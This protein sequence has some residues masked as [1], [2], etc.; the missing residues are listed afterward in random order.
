[1]IVYAILFVGADLLLIYLLSEL[2]VALVWKAYHELHDKYMALS[3]AYEKELDEHTEAI[4]S[5]T[6]FLKK[7]NVEVEEPK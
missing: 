1:M 5:W 3:K 4:N 7:L 6:E 2:R